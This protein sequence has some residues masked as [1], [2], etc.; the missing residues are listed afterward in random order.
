[1]KIGL[2]GLGRMGTAMSQ[3]LR[4]QGFDVVGWDANSERYKALAGSGL[5]TDSVTPSTVCFDTSREIDTA[6]MLPAV[7]LPTR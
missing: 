7:P 4:E 1:M 5:R 3:R 6:P 2:V